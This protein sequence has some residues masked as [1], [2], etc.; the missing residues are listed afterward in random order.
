MDHL[1]R[2]NLLPG[3]D[4]DPGEMI[5]QDDMNDKIKELLLTL[6]ERERILLSLY[7]VDDFTFKNISE[8]LD[9]TEA[10]VCQLHAAAIAKIKTKISR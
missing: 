1:E 3:N 4:M 2:L 9:L 7:Y 8:I 6:P 10:R 5:L